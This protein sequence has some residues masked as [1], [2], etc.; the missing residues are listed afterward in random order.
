MLTF[1]VIMGDDLGSKTKFTCLKGLT[2]ETWQHS[3][4]L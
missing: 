1:M 4:G 2:G 3:L